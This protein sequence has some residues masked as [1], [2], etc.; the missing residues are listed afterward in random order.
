MRIPGGAVDSIPKQTVRNAF[1][2][3]I[4][5]RLRLNLYHDITMGR[6]LIFYTH[7]EIEKYFIQWEVTFPPALKT[8]EL[9]HI[10]KIIQSSI[11]SH[12]RCIMPILNVLP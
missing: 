2:F 1:S 3:G 9:Y 6:K 11:L 4:S 10:L 8:H 5:G 7:T 12:I